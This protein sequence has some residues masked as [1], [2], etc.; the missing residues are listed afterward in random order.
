MEPLLVLI[1]G[2][3]A[4]G[5]V[6]G[7]T[8]GL[9]GVGGGIVI[10]PALL[11]LFHGQEV[12]P[13]IIMPMAVG[14]SLTTIL[15]TNLSATWNHHRRNAV[16]W[17]MVWCYVPGICL[18]ALAGA[19]L[20]NRLPGSVSR[21]WF[22]IFEVV[23]GGRM[24]LS[25]AGGPPR[26]RHWSWLAHFLLGWLIGGISALFGI[27]GGTMTVPA[28]TMLDNVPIRTAVGT[29][30]A[31]GWFIAGF[32]A[33]GFLLTGWEHPLLPWGAVGFIHWPVFA[34]IIIGTLLTTPLGVRLA[35]AVAQDRLKQGFGWFLVVVGIQLIH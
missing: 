19:F 33:M 24:I 8:A 34:G 26:D 32:G 20:A 18:G 23:I 16:H 7:V 31:I 14:T 15:V 28:L 11:W 21:L 22:G 5:L 35:H 17:G 2:A 4:I 6:A 27:G 9:F 30:S 13:A 29:A 1:G 12:N 3:L 25:L 10:V